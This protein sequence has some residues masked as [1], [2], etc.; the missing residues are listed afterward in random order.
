MTPEQ[1][2]VVLDG[3][4]RT[5]KAQHAALTQLGGTLEY[6]FDVA[7]EEHKAKAAKALDVYN[8]SMRDFDALI[9]PLRKIME[10]DQ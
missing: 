9:G 8:A 7:G 5:I 10:G 6:L 1:D 4:W 3:L 2:Q